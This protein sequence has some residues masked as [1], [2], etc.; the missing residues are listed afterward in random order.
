MGIFDT[1]KAH[2]R[3]LGPGTGIMEKLSLGIF[4]S[5]KAGSEIEESPHPI[6]NLLF[7]HFPSP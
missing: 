5:S 3:E 6:S 7:S 2:V 1:D 4:I